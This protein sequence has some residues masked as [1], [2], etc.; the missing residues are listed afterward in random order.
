M[1][2]DQLFTFLDLPLILCDDTTAAVTRFETVRP[3]RAIDFVYFPYAGA[4]DGG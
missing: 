2:S 4:V 1:L 3:K